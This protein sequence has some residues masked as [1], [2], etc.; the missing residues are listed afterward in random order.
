LND[1]A[2]K[3][4]APELGFEIVG[5]TP[6]SSPAFQAAEFAALEEGDPR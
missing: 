2:V 3:A 1:P 5:N 6:S 4:E